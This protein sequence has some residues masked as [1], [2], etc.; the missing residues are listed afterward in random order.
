M[1][2]TFLKS[3][4][5]Q[6]TKSE[7]DSEDGSESGKG[8]CGTSSQCSTPPRHSAQDQQ[9]VDMVPARKGGPLIATPHPDRPVVDN[10]AAQGF[11]GAN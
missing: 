9:C 6:E 5:D 7:H 10:M 3:R 1:D 4:P 11:F 8:A 2:D